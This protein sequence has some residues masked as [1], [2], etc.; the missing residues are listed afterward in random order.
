MVSW[1]WGV[2]A[3]IGLERLAELVVA[4]RNA[5]WSFAQGGREYGRGHYP[6][7][8]AL[9][10]GF[11]LGCIVEARWVQPPTL[12]VSVVCG[13]AALGCQAVRWWVITTLGPRWNTRVIIVPGLPRIVGGPFRYLPHPNYVAVVVEGIVLPGMAGAWVTALVFTLCNALLLRTRIA[14][15]NQALAELPDQG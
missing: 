11:L 9:H 13:V 4:K 5:A 12:W 15:E 14:V 10:T 8:V 2:M 1:Y 3:L 7:M 6:V